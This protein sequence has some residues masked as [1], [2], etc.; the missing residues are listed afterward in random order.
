VHKAGLFL[1]EQA[2]RD[3]FDTAPRITALNSNDCT[4]ASIRTA[5]LRPGSGWRVEGKLC[6]RRIR[7]CMPLSGPSSLRLARLA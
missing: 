7:Q 5:R 3:A 2:V 4:A 6:P 1:G